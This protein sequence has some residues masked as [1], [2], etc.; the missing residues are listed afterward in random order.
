MNIM[1]FNKKIRNIDKKN[2]MNNY[3]KQLIINVNK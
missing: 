2:H 3:Y 1:Q